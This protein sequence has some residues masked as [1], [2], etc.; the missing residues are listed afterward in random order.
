MQFKPYTKH[1]TLKT[2]RYNILEPI[3]E[4]ILP[5]TEL[6]VVLLP[7]IGF[8]LEGFRI[9]TG[10]GYYDATFSFLQINPRPLKPQLIGVGFETQCVDEIPHDEWDVV[11]DGVLT[12]QR[13]IFF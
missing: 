7:L 4:E 5:I 12:D 11:L 1:S 9:G 2:N 10:G 3:T 8:D 6:D 13:L